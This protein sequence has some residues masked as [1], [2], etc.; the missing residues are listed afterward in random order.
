MKSFNSQSTENSRKKIYNKEKFK[1]EWD[2]GL[3]PF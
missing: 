1:N 2:V 3:C